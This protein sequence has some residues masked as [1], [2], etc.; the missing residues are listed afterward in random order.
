M[1]RKASATLREVL[2]AQFAF[3]F[4]CLFGSLGQSAWAGTTTLTFDEFSSGTV[5]T[6]Q[7]ESEGVTI[8]GATALAT[9]AFPPVSGTNIAYAPTGLMTFT[10]NPIV[11]G[12]QVQTVS[13]YVSDNVGS[14]G[15]YAYD[16]SNNL[17]GESFLPATGGVNTLLSVTTSGAPIAYVTIHDAGSQFGVDNFTF[18]WTVTCSGSVEELQSI[19]AALPV[20]DFRNPHTAPETKKL[21]TRDY[22]ARISRGSEESAILDFC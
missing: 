5:L 20:S 21:I 7:Y 6:N 10:F 19:V 16:S 14:A 2:K 11:I 1:E 8:S 4:P 3:L 13:V 9:S 17:L 12:G 15:I 22:P 18:T